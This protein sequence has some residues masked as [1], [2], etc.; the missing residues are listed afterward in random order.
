ME[1]ETENDPWV[2]GWLCGKYQ[3]AG[4]VPCGD[5]FDLWLSGFETGCTENG[6]H[7]VWRQRLYEHV[8]GVLAA[9][10]ITFAD[11]TTL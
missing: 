11:L 8:A 9:L 7:H 5:D 6:E 4:P 1:N 2:L 3:Q 10:I